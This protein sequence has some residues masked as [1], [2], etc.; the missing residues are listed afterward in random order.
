MSKIRFANDTTPPLPSAGKT[1]LFVDQTDGHAK[2]IDSSGD[3]FDLTL[4]GID[5]DTDTI[6]DAIIGGT[7]ITVT[8][9]TSITTIAGDLDVAAITVSGG[10]DITGTIDFVGEGTGNVS[11]A[12]NIITFSAGAGGGGTGTG[13]INDINGEVGPSVTVTGIGGINTITTSNLITITGTVFGTEYAFAEDLTDSTNSTQTF[14]T[15]LTMTKG[16]GQ[17]NGT[18]RIGY[19]YEITA[20]Q[21]QDYEV[22]FINTTGS[23]VLSIYQ[24]EEDEDDF[25]NIISGFTNVVLSGT[26]QTFEIQWRKQSAN[27]NVVTLR[28]TRLEF[29]RV[30]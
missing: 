30:T 17:P 22:Q 18:Y 13:N 25:Q 14:A 23:T 15:K 12:G 19:Y 10:S 5:I 2:T 24:N 4:S 8:S 11:V 21:P 1:V 16:A 6:S 9:G 29:W 20:T 3:V 28:N 7:G 27:A 26:D